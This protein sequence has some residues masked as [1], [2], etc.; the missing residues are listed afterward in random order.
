[1]AHDSI[2]WIQTYITSAIELTQAN[3]WRPL[4]DVYRTKNGWLIKYDLAGVLAEDVTLTVQGSR[5]TL[6]GIRRDC[7]LDEGCNQYYMEISYSQ[8][9]RTIELP[10][11]LDQAH[12][13]T[14]FRHG[15]FLVHIEKETRS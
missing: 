4:V 6:R 5:L 10:D 3:L 2:R 1:M 15:M 14:E 7:C 13:S 9:E 11:D 8:F 12:M